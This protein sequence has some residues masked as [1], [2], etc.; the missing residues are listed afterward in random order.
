V[1]Y[2]CLPNCSS[3]CMQLLGNDDLLKLKFALLLLLV[4]LLCR[5]SCTC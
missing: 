4:L 3:A 1:P 5:A 2:A